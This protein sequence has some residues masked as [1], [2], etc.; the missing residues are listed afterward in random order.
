MDIEWN[1][2]EIHSLVCFEQ[3]FM[4]EKMKNR[5]YMMYTAR[6]Q[7]DNTDTVNRGDFGQISLFS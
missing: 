2:T 3:D 6:S 7:L 5:Q 4:W 1:K